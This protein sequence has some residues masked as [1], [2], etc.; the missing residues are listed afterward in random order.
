MFYIH[1]EDFCQ[2]LVGPFATRED[3]EAHIEF[4]RARG[5]ASV[6]VHNNAVIMAEDEARKTW[7]WEN[8]LYTPEKD[9]APKCWDK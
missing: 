8:N 3:A 2:G 1:G 5:D 4:Q 7:A 9:K 6:V